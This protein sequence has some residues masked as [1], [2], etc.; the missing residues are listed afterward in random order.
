MKHQPKLTLAQLNLPLLDPSPLALPDGKDE[1][2]VQ[3]LVELLLSAV[4]TEGGE[5]HEQADR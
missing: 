4:A 5:K 3:A 2:L 1:R